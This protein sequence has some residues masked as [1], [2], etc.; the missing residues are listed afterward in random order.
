MHF[1]GTY[2]IG[3]RVEIPAHTDYWTQGDRFGEITALR[4]NS[5][6]VVIATVDMDRSGKR[7]CF[8]VDLLSAH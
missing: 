3:Q 8:R 7:R 1:A 4:E 6:G 5:A 2:E